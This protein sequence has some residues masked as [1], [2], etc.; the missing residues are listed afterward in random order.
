M[1]IRINANVSI[2]SGRLA[3]WQGLKNEMQDNIILLNLCPGFSIIDV[4]CRQKCYSTYSIDKPTI[5]SWLTLSLSM[6][7]PCMGRRIDKKEKKEGGIAR[8]HGLGI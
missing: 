2:F 3:Y 6:L 7:S 1:E 8:V 5:N 4:S